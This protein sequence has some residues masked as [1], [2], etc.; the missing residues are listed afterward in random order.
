MALPLIVHLILLL[1]LPPSTV[2]QQQDQKASIEGVVVRIGSGEP[3]SGAEMKLLRVAATIDATPEEAK[4]LGEA[5][6]LPMLPSTATDRNGRFVFKDVDAGSYRISAAR[7]GY[8]KLE[9][10]QRVS[11]GTGTVITV[12]KGQAMKDILFSLT[13]A[14]NVNGT[15]RDVSGEPLTGFQVLL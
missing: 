3:I 9:Y 11:K 12:V 14:G 7:N 10:G 2:Q 13:P 4:S 1:Q 8:A 15:V 6:G 5:I